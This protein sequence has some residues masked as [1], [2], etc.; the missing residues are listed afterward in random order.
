[1]KKE[2]KSK[3]KR[4]WIVGGIAAFASVALLTTGFSVWVIGTSKKTAE[5]NVNISVDTAKNDSVVLNVDLG[6]DP[7]IKLE[8]SKSYAGTEKDFVHLEDNAS[9]SDRVDNPLRLSD[10]TFTLSFSGNITLNDFTNISFSIANPANED[11]Y[12]DFTVSSGNNLIEKDDQKVR[13]G[14]TYQYVKLPNNIDVKTFEKSS[15][16]NDTITTYT[17][18]T[19]LDFSWGNFFESKSPATYYNDVYT[20]PN[21]QTLA[22]GELVKKEFDAM[23]DQLDG[24]K[25]KLIAT[26]NDA[27]PSSN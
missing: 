12:A 1:M 5:G 14:T 20:D 27:T 11:G 6:N 4:K 26:L 9:P 23:H 2:L 17:L 25:I 3:S 15:K 13:K 10:V 16:D 22:N 21:D 19:D 24:K 7:T 18:I 8:E